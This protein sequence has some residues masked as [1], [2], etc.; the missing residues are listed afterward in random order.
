M[1]AD[2]TSTPLNKRAPDKVDAV[3]AAMLK[4]FRTTRN[5][6]QTELAQAVGITF[7]QIQKYETAANRIPASRL[8]YLAQVLEVSV[9]DFFRPLPDAPSIMTQRL[10]AGHRI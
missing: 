8:Y 7:Q 9:A 10:G 6:S 5:M 2:D 3:I 4:T 1:T